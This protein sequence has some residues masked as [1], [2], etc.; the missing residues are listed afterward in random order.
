M[1]RTV[2]ILVTG[3]LLVACKKEV[4]TEPYPT[5]PLGQVNRWVLDSMRRYYYWADDIPSNYDY[6]QHTEIFFQSLLS[7]NDRF[8]WISN[9]QDITA[10]SNS[11]FTYGFHYVLAEVPG[12]NG[13]LGIITLVNKGSSAD[14]A[15]LKR[16]DYF[17]QV[18]GVAITVSNMNAVNL[19]LR[20][21]PEL[22][23]TPAEFQNNAWTALPA[24]SFNQGYAAENPVHYIRSFTADGITTGYLFY[25]SFDENYDGQLLEAIAKLK[26]AGIKELI[27]DLRY[28]AGGS[29][30][31]SAKL[32][33]LLASGLTGNE[34]YV[35][36]Q[37]NHHEGK[38]PRSLQAVLNT[39]GNNIGKQYADLQVNGLNLQRV[40]ILSTKA[41]VSAAE[42]IINNLKPFL[43]VIQLGETTAGKDEASFLI[44]DFRIPKQ[45]FWKMQPTIYKLFN[46]NNHGGYNAGL[47]PQ[48]PVAEIGQLPLY[49]IGE[50]DDPLLKKALQI[51]YSNNIPGNFINLR[52]RRRPVIH[53]NIKYSS[54]L[55][56]AKEKGF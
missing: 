32:A 10:P 34:V 55:Q 26:Q 8:S 37:G 18:N 47:V 35:I 43:P 12:L 42:L 30:A 41:T 36:Y 22:S 45:V 13:L 39:S 46:K 24:V 15:G 1:Q 31:S 50:A 23:L 14:L 7:V 29:V 17:M 11:Y 25:N 48:Y 54:V 2:F 21:G 27:L 56:Q 28:N 3:L 53:L 5:D 49:P 20:T 6:T 16:G 40:F 51:I 9:G 44:E 52:L 38:K 4:T 19:Q 33:A